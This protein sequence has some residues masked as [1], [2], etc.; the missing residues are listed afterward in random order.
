M[1]LSN[2]M[3]KA[4]VESQ[5]DMEVERMGS[6]GRACFGRGRCESGVRWWGTD[7]ETTRAGTTRFFTIGFYLVF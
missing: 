2:D 3:E 7:I 4:K 6:S 1:G 5:D